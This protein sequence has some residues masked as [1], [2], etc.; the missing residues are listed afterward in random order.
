MLEPLTPLGR[1]IFYG[2]AAGL[3]SKE[4]P[5]VVS[6]GER[7][8]V[9][10]TGLLRSARGRAIMVFALENINPQSALALKRL[11]EEPRFS[12]LSSGFPRLPRGAIRFMLRAVYSVIYNLASPS[13]GLARIRKNSGKMLDQVQREL[14]E[15]HDLPTWWAYMQADSQL[16][17][18]LV[19]LLAPAVA[20]GQV[21]YQRLR[22]MTE[23]M[24][25][26]AL[27]LAELN[28]S[29]PHNP[30][31]E[32]DLALWRLSRT[33]RRDSAS[34][35]CFLENDEKK[36]S[37]LYR[38]A[39]LP[40]AAQQAA[41]GFLALYGARGLGEIDLGHVRW[42][43]EPSPLFRMLKSYLPMEEEDS[44]E[45]SFSEGEAIA[46]KALE[47]LVVLLRAKKQAGMARFL[48]GR[49]RQLG[50]LRDLP[51]FVIVRLFGVL[52]HSALNIGGE[53]VSQ[54]VFNEPSD[55]FFLKMAELDKLAA[56]AANDWQSLIATR[57]Q[58]FAREMN[59]RQV[60]HILLSDGTAF[61]EGAPESG[62]QD[63]HCLS[64]FPVSSGLVE[65][66]VRV[67]LDPRQANLKK[68][69]IM[70]CSSTDPSWTP[71]FLSISGLVMEVGG[72]MTHGSVVAREY[73]IPALVGVT[74]ATTR[75][76]TGQRIR[77][78]GSGGKIEI[79]TEKG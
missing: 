6:A 41:A 15:I 79:L 53:L 21:P 67:V 45:R 64:G 1:E 60:P 19:P 8:F 9:D 46:E 5:P 16:A 37:E 50:G 24:E 44:P 27:L 69:E 47:K 43:E 65:G 51:K 40:P 13:A 78:D 33:I 11:G 75:L 58:A 38:S 22:M 74:Q 70:V 76:Q 35:Q 59:R 3:G 63:D 49:F 23:G 77:L 10:V 17:G 66:V 28:R 72:S 18:M 42:G 48:G 56:G 7:L 4:H 71:L 12:I 52:R 25:D 2:I 55:I 36:L 73:G 39:S 54:G 68:G 20:S 30:T 57:R 32:M 29:L 34:E 31:T 26:G 62:V 14:A 61:Y